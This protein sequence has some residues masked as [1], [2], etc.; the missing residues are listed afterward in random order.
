V[1]PQAIASL[2][3]AQRARLTVVQQAREEQLEAVR[4][5]YRAAGV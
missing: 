5:A 1:I 4:A 2:P 3:E